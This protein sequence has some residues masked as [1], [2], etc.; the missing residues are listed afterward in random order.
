MHQTN[1]TWFPS[2]PIGRV[3]HDLVIVDDQQGKNLLFA[4]SVVKK[5]WR[6]LAIQDHAKLVYI[7]QRNSIRHSSDN[8]IHTEI[9]ISGSSNSIDTRL[10][11]IKNTNGWREQMTNRISPTFRRSAR[12]L[13]LTLWRRCTRRNG[14]ILFVICSCHPFV[15]LIKYNLKHEGAL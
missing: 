7:L 2:Y 6:W 4:N 10:Y 3:S 8:S 15:S 5:T 13:S 14:D 12:I 11:F 9:N 1:S